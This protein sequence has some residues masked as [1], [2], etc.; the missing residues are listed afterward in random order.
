MV[1][2]T[3]NLNTVIYQFYLRERGKRLVGVG[4]RE[5]DHVEISLISPTLG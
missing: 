1:L 4:G 2:Y 5:E 3:C